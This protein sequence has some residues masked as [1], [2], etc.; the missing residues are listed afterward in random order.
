VTTEIP[1]SRS[2]FIQSETGAAPLALGLTCPARYDGAA[3]QQQFLRSACLAGV[4]MRVMAKVRRRATSVA[5]GE[6][7]AIRQ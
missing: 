7:A 2:I 1:R 4:R 5:I 6:R 3:E